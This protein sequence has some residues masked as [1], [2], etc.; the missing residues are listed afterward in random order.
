ML[1][2]GGTAVGRLKQAGKFP[3]GLYLGGARKPFGWFGPSTPY[4]PADFA[5]YSRYGAAGNGLAVRRG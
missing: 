5:A 3:T 4:R 1:R 2:H